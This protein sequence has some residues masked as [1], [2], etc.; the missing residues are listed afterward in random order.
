[1]FQIS[2]C[3]HCWVKVKEFE[4]DVP[5]S[6]EETAAAERWESLLYGCTLIV[7]WL[8]W[9]L[10]CSRST[11]S[12]KLSCD[13]PKSRTLDPA[14][15]SVEC[16]QLTYAH[17]QRKVADGPDTTP[18]YYSNELKNVWF[19]CIFIV[20][21]LLLFWALGRSSASS[22]H[23]SALSARA[24][25][26]YSLKAHWKNITHVLLNFRGSFLCVFSSYRFDKRLKNSVLKTDSSKLS[27]SC[28]CRM[29]MSSCIVLKRNQSIYH[30][31]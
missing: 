30:S 21:C 18:I 9:P 23:S 20:Y 1:M 16:K 27:Y 3:F 17:R 28:S 13:R 25:I 19:P 4:E 11:D 5:F 31:D 29:N 26:I 14:E 8:A 7:Q 24:M 15:C 12:T 22:F 2:Q 6:W 10:L